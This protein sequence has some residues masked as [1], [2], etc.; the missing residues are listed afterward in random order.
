MQL[1]GHNAVVTAVVGPEIHGNQD[2]SFG[3]SPKLKVRLQMK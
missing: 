1:F 2:K 3:V